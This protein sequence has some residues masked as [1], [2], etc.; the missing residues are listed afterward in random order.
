M[1]DLAL[2]LRH[3]RSAIL[4]A[5]HGSFRRA[6]NAAD[7]PQSTLT[8]RI[9]MLETR[10]GVSLFERSRTGS[11]L[12]PAGEHFIRDAAIG[13]EHL[14]QVVRGLRAMKVG[15]SGLL[16]IGVTSS[17]AQGPVGDLLAA[18]R[19][20]FPGVSV[21]V[22]E[23]TSDRNT[24]AVASG[25]L[26]VAFV[27]G[28]QP[29]PCC[30]K[31]VV[32]CESLFAAVPGDHKLASAPSVAWDDL[33]DQIVLISADGHGPEVEGIVLR[34]LSEIGFR[35][36]LSL[37]RVGREN[38]LNLVGKGFGLTVVAG[39]TLGAVYP[40]VR[41]LPLRPEAERLRWSAIWSRTN[42]NSLL[43][44]LLDLIDELR[45]QEGAGR[46]RLNV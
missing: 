18:Y 7:L 15:E 17:L 25:R 27:L 40:G 9:Q 31:K 13:A 5:E 3:L 11:R 2:D 38:L 39:S 29:L 16:R 19:R 46:G 10:L 45:S 44:R 26:D 22:E 23:S 41:F 35:P 37:Q 12:T 34:R 24:A 36:R 42:K 28:S 4:V 14:Q 20:K 8:R 43:T 32:D 21:L 1:P 30:E 33:R 6:A